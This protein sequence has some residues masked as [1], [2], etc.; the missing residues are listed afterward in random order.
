[1][2]NWRWLILKV[3]VIVMLME[4]K[5]GFSW[6]LLMFVLFKILFCC[7]KGRIC[8]LLKIDLLLWWY[9]KEIDRKNND[10]LYYL[11]LYWGRLIIVISK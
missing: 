5:I 3:Y 8:D 2:K 7:N 11:F 9:V 1:M 4:K 6:V 10:N